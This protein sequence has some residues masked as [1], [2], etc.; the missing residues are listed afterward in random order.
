[1]SI[2]NIELFQTCFREIRDTQYIV[3]ER[4]MATTNRVMTDSPI[5]HRIVGLIEKQGKKEKDLTDYI[6][7]SPGTMSKWKYDGSNVY[8]KY[9]VEI[10]EFLET[11]PNYLFLG[12]DD[13]SYTQAEKD[14]IRKYRS[15]DNGRKKCIRDTLKYFTEGGSDEQ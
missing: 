11:T 8:L 15:L 9:I 7:I 13:E 1:M 2:S 4:T 5:V 6:G 3:E 12:S 10:C 14:M